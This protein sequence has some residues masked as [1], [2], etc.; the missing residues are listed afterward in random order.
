MTMQEI[1]NEV[2]AYGP[3]GSVVRLVLDTNIVVSGLSP[4]FSEFIDES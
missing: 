4:E 2:N 3:R 1:Q